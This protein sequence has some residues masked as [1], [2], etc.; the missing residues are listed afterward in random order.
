[1]VPT[2][3]P[4]IGDDVLR[5]SE[6]A[7]LVE[8]WQKWDGSYV[9]YAHR[10]AGIRQFQDLNGRVVFSYQE[11]QANGVAALEF[12]LNCILH[13][14]DFDSHIMVHQGDFCEKITRNSDWLGF[15]DADTEN[16]CR[17]WVWG[18]KAAELVRIEFK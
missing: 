3:T 6:P 2:S 12:R 5:L 8:L 13:D 9:L 15:M 17:S 10:K 11:D 14:V 4:Q 7:N 1:M 16:F 18:E